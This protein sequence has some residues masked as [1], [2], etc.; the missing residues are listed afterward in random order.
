MKQY[1]LNVEQSRALYNKHKTKIEPKN[2]YMNIF[3]VLTLY[4]RVFQP[5]SGRLLMDT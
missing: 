1:A 3:H 2:C 5:A 4:P